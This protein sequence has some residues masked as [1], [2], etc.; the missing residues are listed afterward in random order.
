MDYS[1]QVK[2]L[3]K[4]KQRKLRKYNVLIVGCGALGSVVANLLSR[5]GVSLRLV[6]KDKVEESNLHRTL[7][8]EEDI[9]KPKAKTLATVLGKSTDANIEAKQVE[10][11]QDNASSL[12]RGCGLILDGTDNMETRFLMSDTSVRTGIPYIYAAVLKNQGLVATFK[13][14]CLRCLMGEIGK[15][16]KTTRQVGVLGTAPASVGAVQASEAIKYMTTDKRK[17]QLISINLEGNE[18]SASGFDKDPKC[19]CKTFK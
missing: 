10:F 15:T 1:R 2:Y 4:K 18:F 9:G 6:D 3:G 11:K 8:R 17:N 12:V 5:A 13:D 19:V 14:A 16:L 7:F